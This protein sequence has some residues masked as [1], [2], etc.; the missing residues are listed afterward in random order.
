MIEEDRCG[1]FRYRG[2]RKVIKNLDVVVNNGNYFDSIGVQSDGRL[3][4]MTVPKINTG[5]YK[6]RY[7]Y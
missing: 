4:F 1:A 6:L 7:R 2:R 5:R 3:I